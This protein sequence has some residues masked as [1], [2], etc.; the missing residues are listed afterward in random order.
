[1]P[2][3][4]SPRSNNFWHKEKPIKPAEPVTIII[5]YDIILQESPSGLAVVVVSETQIFSLDIING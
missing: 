1:M 5:I 2:M 4:L 3:I